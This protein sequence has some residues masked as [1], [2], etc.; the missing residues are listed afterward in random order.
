[1]AYVLK[2]TSGLISTRITDTGRKKL[3]EGT[4]NIAYFQVGDSEVSYNTLPASYSQYQSFVLE[5]CFNSQNSAGA[6]Q[7]NK[8]N[9]KYPY[10]VDGNQGNT[11]G[12]PYMESVVRP[13]FNAA[14][15]RGFFTSTTI[16]DVTYWSSWTTNYY[17]LNS[18]YM[19]D[20]TSLTGG[21]KINLIFDRCNGDS[22]RLPS[23]GD[24][25][26]IYY[27]GS[28]DTNCNCTVA[29]TPTPT[30]TSTTTPTFGPVSPTPTPSATNTNPCEP[31]PSP[32]PSNTLPIVPSPTPAYLPPPPD[33]CVYNMQGCHSILTYRIVAVCLNELTLD[34]ATPDFSYLSTTQYGRVFVY[35][36]N[37]TSL[38]DGYT[39]RP[40]WYD[41][42]VN[43]DSVCGVDTFD[44]KVWNMNIP[45]SESPAGLVE[46]SYDGYTKF[47]SIGYLGTKEYLGYISPSGQSAT[48]EVYFYNSFD[49][50]IVVNPDEQKAIAVVHYTN[51]TI[52]YFYGEKFALEPFDPLEVDNTIGQARNFKVSLPWLMWHK[53]PNCCS[54][55]TFYVDPA[56]FDGLDLFQVQYIKSLK[57]PDMNYPGIRY[58]NLWDTNPNDDGYPSR[59]GKVFPDQKIIVFDDEEI[60]AAMSYKSNRNWTLPAPRTSLVTPN[61]CGMDNE[62]VQGILSAS[63]EYLYVTYRLTNSSGF[64]NSLHCN[65]YIK[66]QGPNITCNPI[67][68]QNVAVRFG[69]EFG[70]LNFQNYICPPDN[71]YGYL[72]DTFEIVCQK[73]VGENRPDPS[74]WKI[75]DYTSQ[76]SGYTSNGYITESGLT[77]NTF[78]ITQELY[79][80]AP[81]YDLGDYISLT[82]L[83]Y[84]GTSLNFGDEFYFYGN[85][86]TDIQATIYEMRYK[87]NLGQTEFQNSTNPGWSAGTASYISEIGLYDNEKNLIVI[88]KLQSPV[89]RQGIQQFLVKFDF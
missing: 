36:P 84:T 72:A 39:P 64:T 81:F 24:F 68:S 73:V 46:T 30:P 21:T 38:Y 70:C 58:Y 62:S 12:I 42:V 14:V 37:M 76:L 71:T 75:I 1:M 60:I 17:T 89:P 27:D 74:E 29:V 55:Q 22:V 19:V 88:S 57:N 28:G 50:K 33:A 10:F 67:V 85:I 18:N 3:S 35:P 41:N 45:W 56:G 9:I 80:S 48:T 77:A 20:L 44:V 53:S 11:Y 66:T 2:N 61:T 86:E 63:T 26:T 49:D 82:P 4:F 25:I 47:G 31:S 7:S 23:V 32:T 5:P 8:Q 54:G 59:V 43:Y 83:N 40:H 52:D 6:P 69:G 34:R 16:D 51:N 78:V 87:V 65:Y 79:D 13:V 15:P